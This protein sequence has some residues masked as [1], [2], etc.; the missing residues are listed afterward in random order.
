MTITGIL[1]DG[2]EIKPVEF[3]RELARLCPGQNIRVHQDQVDTYHLV[4]NGRD[5]D[6]CKPKTATAGQLFMTSD[7]LFRC[8]LEVYDA[9]GRHITVPPEPLRKKRRR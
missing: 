8:R 7:A 9:A 6:L 4:W 3:Y 1:P 2:T 5:H